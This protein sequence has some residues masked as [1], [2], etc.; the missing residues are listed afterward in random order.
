MLGGTNPERAA[1]ASAMTPVVENP[2]E[3]HD[4]QAAADDLPEVEPRLGPLGREEGEDD[5]DRGGQEADDADEQGAGPAAGDGDRPSG[6]R[7]GCGELQEGGEQIEIRNEIED[8]GEVGEEEVRL[9][10]VNP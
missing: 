6:R 4:Q 5:G 3:Q 7:A 8:D 1:S 10:D 2:A 9:L